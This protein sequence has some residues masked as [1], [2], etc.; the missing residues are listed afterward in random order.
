VEYHYNLLDFYLSLFYGSLACGHK[1]DIWPGANP[2]SAACASISTLRQR[3][4]H[5]R[6]VQQRAPLR[7]RL[8]NRPAE[9][10]EMPIIILRRPITSSLRCI[11]GWRQ[12]I[13]GGKGGN[14]W[15]NPPS[16]IHQRYR[17]LRCFLQRAVGAGS[18]HG[19]L[20][21]TGG[22]SLHNFSSRNCP[23]FCCL[24]QGVHSTL[25]S[26]PVA[27]IAENAEIA[28]GAGKAFFPPSPFS[29]RPH[30]CVRA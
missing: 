27:E 2:S 15:N 24:T 3:P 20:A 17:T 9:I 30:V 14:P 19:G 21:Q 29:L 5:F 26:K 22:Y 28:G 18:A 4:R 25:H 7:S 10:P 16:E 6:L 11:H 13:S 12:E 1:I 8:S 23:Q